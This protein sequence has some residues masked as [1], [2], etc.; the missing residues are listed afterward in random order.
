MNKDKWEIIHRVG[1]Q[2]ILEHDSLMFL[3]TMTLDTREREKQIQSKHLD[4]E[5][6]YGLEYK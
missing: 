4:R 5:D 1:T 3:T 2:C 6:S